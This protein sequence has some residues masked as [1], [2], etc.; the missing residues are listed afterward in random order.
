MSTIY[1]EEAAKHTSSH[2][3]SDYSK[4]HTIWSDPDV[5]WNDKSFE[6]TSNKVKAS[7]LD[8]VMPSAKFILDHIF[9]VFRFW[10]INLST[11]IRSTICT[12]VGDPNGTVIII[13]HRTRAVSMAVTTVPRTYPAGIIPIT[14]QISELGNKLKFFSYQFR[15]HLFGALCKQ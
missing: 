3:S 11:T 7:L 8:F 14:T 13:I 9:F 1:E 15:F 2:R 5:S 4:P 10:L 12:T 6:S